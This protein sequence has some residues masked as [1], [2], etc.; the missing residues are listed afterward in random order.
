M[1]PK[2][3]H[4][5]EAVI[6]HQHVA[7]LF[8]PQID[9]AN[10]DIIGV[11]ALARWDG[12]DTPEEL[13]QR[14]AASGLAER[15]SRLVQR[16]ALRLAAI[17]EGPLKSLDL[18][19]NLLPQ[20]LARAGYDQWLLDEIDIA[21]IDPRRITV[22]IT[23]SALLSDSDS[24]AERLGRLRAAG[25]RVAVDDFGT[26][27]A[28]LAY[29]TSLPLDILKIDR[30]LVADIVGGTRDRIVVK[31]MIALARELDLQVVVEG[32]ESTAQ[33]A[34]LAD[35][36]CDLYQGFLGAG[37]LDEIELARFV[38]ASMAQAA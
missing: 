9:P 4:V 15:L 38:A 32:V 31:A 20:D 12:A 8:Q 10:G 18:S 26:G 25:I 24:I 35:W 17:W 13:F 36:G 29:L 5:L 6:A 2:R 19:I 27:Y 14:A 34:L 37:P 3:D 21:G 28:S 7:L 1:I 22:E 30:G 23:E 16:K 33:L 11:E